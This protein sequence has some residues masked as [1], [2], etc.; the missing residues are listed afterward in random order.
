M[1]VVELNETKTA[2]ALHPLV[3]TP[4]EHENAMLAGLGVAITEEGVGVVGGNPVDIHAV[5]R[6]HVTTMMKEKC[7]E[8]LVRVLAHML[9]K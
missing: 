6:V 4:A 1:R 5:V 9:D 3:R 8:G 2:V 7:V